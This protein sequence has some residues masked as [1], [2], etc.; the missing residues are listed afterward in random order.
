MACVS[1]E[2][3]FAIRMTPRSHFVAVVQATLQ[4]LFGELKHPL[5]ARIP[6]SEK[7]FHILLVRLGRI[8]RSMSVIRS[9]QNNVQQATLLEPVAYGMATR[10]HP[11]TNVGILEKF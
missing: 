4:H 5:Q 1:H 6:V 3:E 8:P 9:D 7:R 10:T 11:A 2:G